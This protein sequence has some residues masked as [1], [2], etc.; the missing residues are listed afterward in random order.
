MDRIGLRDLNQRTSQI[1]DRV[2]RGESLVVT[3]R[4]EPIAKLVPILPSSSV[5]EELVRAGKA[6]PPRTR[7]PLPPPVDFGDPS[8]DSATVIRAL[9]DEE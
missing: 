6:V 8:L 7:A 5:L 4:G 9:R 1:L 2:R 3:D